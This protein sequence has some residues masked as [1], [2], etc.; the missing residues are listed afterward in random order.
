MKMFILVLLV[1]G[2]AGG[3][4]GW[5][6]WDGTQ[7]KT[8]YRTVPVTKGDIVSVISATGTVEPEEVV[9]VGAQVQ[10]KVE[11]L[12]RDPQDSTK[13]I[14]YGSSVSAGTIL[15]QIDDAVYASQV[16]QAKA[17]LARSE[18][19]MQQWLAKLNQAERDWTRVNNLFVKSSVSAADRDLSLANLETA[20]AQVAVGKAAVN[21]AK[22]SLKQSEISL[23]Y[24]TIKS[25]VKGVI[26][27]RRV[28]IG[29]TVVASLNAPSLF[30]IAKDLSKLQVWASVNEADIGRIYKNQKVKFTVDAFPRDKFEGYVSQIRLNA[31]STQNVVTYTV[32]VSTDNPGGKLLPYLTA[33]VQFLL[34]SR[35]NVLTV[36][37]AALRWRP[38]G[39]DPKGGA[40][41]GES[42][43]PKSASSASWA[44]SAGAS[45]AKTGEET[46]KRRKDRKDASKVN[47]DSGDGGAT[48]DRRKDTR[49]GTLWILEGEQIRALE[50]QVGLKDGTN[51]EVSGE[52]LTE[53][54]Q[55]VTGEIRRTEETSG[56]KSPF[57]PQ[58][59][60]R[61]GRGGGGGGGR[62]GK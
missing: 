10:G 7:T 46:G 59:G 35:E 41:R 27:D 43:E 40:D 24:T 3:G 26:V 51:S 20:K 8:T 56:G 6:V 16:E 50:V 49:A 52:G 2:A 19:D 12:G 13:S 34:D 33:N 58:F 39:S 47:K 29:Q 55:V 36:P 54:M 61:G 30:L 48:E 23:S 28:N 11:T 53:G 17:N 62:G 18:A 60:G 37:N 5:Y 44:K 32:V 1:L 57:A 15:A 31:M 9:D 45:T 21:Q 42:R 4:V 25:P 38:K 14:D 22:A